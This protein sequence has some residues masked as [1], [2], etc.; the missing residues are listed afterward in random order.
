MYITKF[1]GKVLIDEDHP[2][3]I[4]ERGDAGVA[5]WAGAEEAATVEPQNWSRMRKPDLLAACAE[6]GI[7]V[8]EE[9]TRADLIAL[10]SDWE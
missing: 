7:V 5:G 6:V 9:M 1:G 8:G 10:L 2:L 3:A 4:A